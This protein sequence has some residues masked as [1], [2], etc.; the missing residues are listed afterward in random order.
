MAFF[1]WL[2]E[3]KT[4]HV[5]SEYVFD[6]PKT[7]EYIL[8]NYLDCKEYTIRFTYVNNMSYQEH[9]FAFE[10]DRALYLYF[11]SKDTTPLQ[12][13]MEKAYYLTLIY[14]IADGLPRL[15][16][17]LLDAINPEKTP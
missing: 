10:Q 5:P 14:T 12:R 4:E 7:P 2:N 15:L 16:P 11:D 9:R 1:S 8:L 6:A 3:A 13:S 17:E